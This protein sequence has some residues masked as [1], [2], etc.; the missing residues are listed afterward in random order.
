[1]PV[2][3]GCSTNAHFAKKLVPEA[4][5]HHDKSSAHMV[6]I[7]QCDR[8]Q[9]CRKFNIDNP[10]FDRLHRLR[11]KLAGPIYKLVIAN[12]VV[13]GDHA[14]NKSA[15][16]RDYSPFSPDRVVNEKI[17]HIESLQHLYLSADQLFSSEVWRIDLM[18]VSEGDL[19]TTPAPTPPQPTCSLNGSFATSTRVRARVTAA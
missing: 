17:K 15:P 11:E 7:G 12:A 1:M 18:K 2:P 8:L 4:R 19:K 10:A 16:P 9:A 14:T 13:R 5:G 3:D 6:A